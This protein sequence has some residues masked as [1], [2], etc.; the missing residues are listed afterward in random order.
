MLADTF[1]REHEDR[2]PASWSDFDGYLTSPVDSVFYHI[3]PSKRYAFLSKPLN[4]PAPHLGNLLI[5]TRRPFR[6]GRLYANFFGGISHGLRE[7]GRYIIYRT[8]SGQFQASYVD[9][10]YVQQ[11]FRGSEALL[12]S[13]DT[14][15]LRRHET[16][17]RKRS[18]ITWAV[19]AAIP[20]T[21]LTWRFFRRSSTS[22]DDDRNA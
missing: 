15:P 6:D 11:A 4:L 17:A 19:A 14:E 18:I 1:A 22:A 7:P 20:I 16:D 13:P 21:L 3:I 9:E 2:S 8:Q 10:A 5:I 12:P